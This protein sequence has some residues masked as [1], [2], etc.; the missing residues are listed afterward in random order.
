MAQ[1]ATA[2]NASAAAPFD[3]EVVFNNITRVIVVSKDDLDGPPMARM[4]FD[5]ALK[6]IL[7]AMWYGSNATPA[8]KIT[9]L[10]NGV[11]LVTATLKIRD[12]SNDTDISS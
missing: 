12:F 11:N 8:Q 10:K 1:T 4:Q 6:V 9:A 7:R 3:V 5:E 2:P